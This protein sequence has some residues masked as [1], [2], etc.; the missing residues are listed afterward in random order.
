MLESQLSALTQGTPSSHDAI[1]HWIE[2]LNNN[3][4][5][6]SQ[7]TSGD[8]DDA[9]DPN[10]KDRVVYILSDNYD[11]IE[12]TAK[13]DRILKDGQFSISTLTSNAASPPARC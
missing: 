10:Y 12:I 4:I 9:F 13:K 6:Q 11:S 3:L 8:T 2:K 1:R 5:K 7:P